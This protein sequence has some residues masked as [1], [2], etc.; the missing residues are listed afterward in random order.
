MVAARSQAPGHVH[1][2][3]PLVWPTPS[4]VWTPLIVKYVE[5]G[6]GKSHCQDKGPDGREK[7]LGYHRKRLS[8]W[9]GAPTDRPTDRTLAG[10]GADVVSLL[11]S[12]SLRVFHQIKAG[13]A[14][15]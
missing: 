15:A 8:A 10:Q 5:K 12:C 14:A 3:E 4:S 11:S 7:A 6:M 1:A 13:A 9:A 2:A